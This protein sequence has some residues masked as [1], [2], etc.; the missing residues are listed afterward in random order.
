MPWLCRQSDPVSCLCVHWEVRSKS[1]KIPLSRQLLKMGTRWP[2]TCWAT[3]KEQLIR[4]NNYNTKWHLVGFLFHIEHVNI[5]QMCLART[6]LWIAQQRAILLF[7]LVF[8]IVS[9]RQVRHVPVTTDTLHYRFCLRVFRGPHGRNN[10]LPINRAM[11]KTR[12]VWGN[13]RQE[14]HL[15]G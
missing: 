6:Y 13:G 2:E 14:E 5:M 1:E 11:L 7:V 3:Y 8:R 12:N 9:F 4:R 10:K 15:A